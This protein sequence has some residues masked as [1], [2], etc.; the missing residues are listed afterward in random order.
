MINRKHLLVNYVVREEFVQD[1][2]TA[3][4]AV[5]EELKTIGIE[6][7]FYSIY[8]VGTCSFIHLQCFPSEE[9]SRKVFELPSF[10]VFFRKLEYAFEME[11]MANDVQKIGY[12][13]AADL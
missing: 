5:L 7:V 12:Y 8:Q 13:D 10:Q 11:P 6:N 3:L 2:I 1:I 4:E 9:I